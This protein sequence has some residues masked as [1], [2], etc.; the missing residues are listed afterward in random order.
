MTKSTKVEKPKPVEVVASVTSI[1][2]S[3]DV[4]VATKEPASS[5][6]GP[7][8]AGARRSPERKR[9]QSPRDTPEE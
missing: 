8:Q 4:A 5:E 7:R 2:S 1:L 6:S 3:G 9:K